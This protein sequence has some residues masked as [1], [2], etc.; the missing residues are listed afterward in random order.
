MFFYLRACAPLV[1]FLGEWFFIFAAL[2]ERLP[3]IRKIAGR[4]EAVCMSWFVG[5]IV[6][7]GCDH[8]FTCSFCA[9][10]LIDLGGFAGVRYGKR[11]ALVKHPLFPADIH[12]G[13][14]AGCCFDNLILFLRHVYAA[15]SRRR[16]SRRYR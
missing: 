14:L 15:G 4:T 10:H 12:A 11:A 7:I 5:G 3:R 1:A 2:L 8:Y 16:H 9:Q 13:N 6:F